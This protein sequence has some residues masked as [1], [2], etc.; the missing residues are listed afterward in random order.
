[1]GKSEI[2][3][4]VIAGRI[5]AEI[6]GVDLAA[7]LDDA[8]VASVRAA[9]LRWKVVFFR[10][11]R[12]DADGQI[13][14]GGRFG[15]PTG[16]HPT[17][18]GL[19]EHPEVLDVDARGGNIAVQW[20]TD[21]TF[22]DRPPLGSILRAVVVPPVGGDTLWANTVAAYEDLPA[23]L[24]RLAESLQAVHTN[25]FD[26]AEVRDE[27]RSQALREYAKVFESERYETHH[28]VV[29][30]HPET[31]ERALLLGGFARSLV[32]L[33]APDSSGLLSLFRR[34]VERPENT[35]RWRW[36]PGD[37]AFWDN[38]ATQHRAIADFGSAAR[39]LQRV[40]LVGDLPIG[41]DGRSSK[42]LAGDSARYNR[43]AA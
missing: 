26:Y 40:T 4:H 15:V 32:G 12:L 21:V 31:G 36:R 10:D 25:Q 7:P 29:R 18:P 5:G 28:P 41:V 42:S 2:E 13:A 9:L 27:R 8:V 22:I 20:H 16:A 38:R 6:R 37:V 39:R 19:R 35:V 23:D 43:E 34:H 14:L 24:Q 1:M 17:V 30:V 11:Q 3:V 33:S